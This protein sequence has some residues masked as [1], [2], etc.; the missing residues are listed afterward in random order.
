MDHC[1]TK[2]VPMSST[3]SSPR[4]RVRQVI[5][6]LDNLLTI[7]LQGYHRFSSEQALNASIKAHIHSLKVHPDLH[8]VFR[9]FKQEYS[10]WFKIHLWLLENMVAEWSDVEKLNVLE[11]VELVRLRTELEDADGWRQS[12]RSVRDEDD[13]HEEEDLSWA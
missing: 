5:R 12:V 8:S 13:D 4:Q 1:S 10:S 2:A 3:Q 6:A 9:R 11:G 7:K